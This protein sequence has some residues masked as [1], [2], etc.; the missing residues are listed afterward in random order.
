MTPFRT[1]LGIAVSSF[2]CLATPNLS[3]AEDSHDH[4]PQAAEVHDH[5]EVAVAAERL[6]FSL[7]RGWTDP[8]VHSDFSP[9]G[10]PLVHLFGLEP[11]FLD[12]DLFVD[13]AFTK[14]EDEEESELALE[15]EY[16]LTRR[17]GVVVEAPLVSLN[18][19]AGE[20][21]TGLGDA[22]I[23][24]RV[25]LVE[26]DRFLLSG[27]LELAFPTGSESRGLGSG[28][29][30]IGPSVSTWLDLGNWVTLSTQ[31]GT[32]HGTE[33]GDS[34]LSYA[35]ALTWS[36]RGPALFPAQADAHAGHGHGRG[37]SHFPPGL[38]SLILEYTGRTALSGDDADRSTGEV[39]FGLS[40]VLTES[41]EVRGAYQLPV[42]G[43]HDIDY[44]YVFGIIYHF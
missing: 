14:G 8:W 21:E 44:G 11:A 22:A 40:H 7:D 35:A 17:I 26:T 18:P 38:T 36:F 33:S 32:E 28:E 3:A 19:D 37:A 41:L 16:A 4:A 29:V 5:V 20:T 2:A 6:G 23:A 42:G 30:A 43:T 39:L 9:R 10:T 13:Y 25:L 12:R 27:N 34:E 15:L 31:V 1:R 24:P